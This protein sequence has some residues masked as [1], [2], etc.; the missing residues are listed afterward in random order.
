MIVV[1]DL[2][3]GTRYPAAEKLKDDKAHV[4]LLPY[5]HTYLEVPYLT[6]RS[7]L[8]CWGNY[9]GE[10]EIK[11]DLGVVLCSLLPGKYGMPG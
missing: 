3:Q 8:V 9:V 2:T 4:I 10:N 5:R 1:V 11:R 7:T 6:S